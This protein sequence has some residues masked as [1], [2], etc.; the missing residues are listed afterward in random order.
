MTHEFAH[1]WDRGV[2]NVPDMTGARQLLD[3]HDIPILAKRLGLA[4]PFGNVL[5][6][7]CGTGRL[8]QH[9]NGRYIGVDIA[10]AAVEY[11]EQHGRQAMLIS[12][13]QDLG[14]FGRHDL[15]VA[16]SVFTHIDEA[17]RA[18]YLAAFRLITQRILVDII[19][20]DG[21]GDVALWSAI[22]KTF[23]AQLA[24]YGW[25]IRASTEMAWGTDGITH[26]Y[27][28]AELPGR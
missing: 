15:V 24:K 10:L 11:C 19:P 16:L 20:G 1:Y 18:A 7:G 27:Y 17:E 28:Y 4:L 8:A 12:G 21:T 5:D 3:A 23:E 6:V 26:R 9:V 22:P 2:A 14:D 25:K 13:A